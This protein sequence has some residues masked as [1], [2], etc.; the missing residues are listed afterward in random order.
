MHLLIL[1]S[2]NQ[3]SPNYGARAK[4]GQRSYFIQPAQ[5]FRPSVRY[6][7]NNEKIMHLQKELRFGRMQ[8]I[9]ETNTLRKISGP[10]IVV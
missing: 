1:I 6:F 9:P 8:L 4:S 10:R 3:G 7:V 2:L 5:P